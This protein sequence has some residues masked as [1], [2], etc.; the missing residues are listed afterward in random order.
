[1]EW[2]WF[3]HSATGGV[4]KVADQPGIREYYIRRGWGEVPDPDLTPGEPIVVPQPVEELPQWVTLY[5]PKVEAY[6]D[7]PNNPGALE[8]ARAAGWVDA[9]EPGEPTPGDAPDP[10][11]VIEPNPPEPTPVTAKKGK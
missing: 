9:P 7:F 8:G 11:V 2:L 6:H 4:T 3:K 1:M 10:E 5:H